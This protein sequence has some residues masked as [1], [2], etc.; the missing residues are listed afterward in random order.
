MCIGNASA[1]AEENYL[2]LSEKL[3]KL[4]GEVSDLSNELQQMRDEH[5]L[6]MRG[7][8]TQKNTISENIKQEDIAFIRLK[9]DLITNKMLI[10]DIGADKETIKASLL[11][12]TEKL[13]TYVSTGLPFKIADRLKSIESYEVNLESGVLSSHKAANTLWSMIEDELKLARDNGI[14][15]QSILIEEKEY[16]AHVA[17][18]G[19]VLMYFKISDDGYGLFKKTA[20]GWTAVLTEDT[21]DIEQ[22]KNLF[23]SLEKQIRVGYFE[24]PNV[25]NTDIYVGKL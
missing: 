21:A 25:L 11:I 18:I 4:R 19:M 24:L 17:K 7:L 16:L 10:K 15:R 3:V 5:K 6:E 20:N 8:I 22:I 12:E 2:N 9:D 1:D 13:K 14:Y 23:N